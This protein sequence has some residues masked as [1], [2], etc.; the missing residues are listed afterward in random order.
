MSAYRIAR[1]MSSSCWPVLPRPGGIIRTPARPWGNSTG[2]PVRN[3][4]DKEVYTDQSF[5]P[6]NL[7]LVLSSRP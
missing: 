6:D 3:F 2:V 7:R 5:P 4:D 1:L